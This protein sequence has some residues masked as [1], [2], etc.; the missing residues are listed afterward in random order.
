MDNQDYEIQQEYFAD[1]KSKRQAVSKIQPKGKMGYKKHRLKSNFDFMSAKERKQLNGEV[2]VSN[3]YEDIKNIPTKE[4][5]LSMNFDEAKRV[6]GIAKNLHT[7][8]ALCEQIGTSCGGLYTLYSKFQIPV[9]KRG[10]VKGRTRKPRE[11]KVE[12]KVDNV[13]RVT[14]IKDTPNDETMNKIATLEDS[15]A[16][17]STTIAILQEQL[18]KR[19]QETNSNGFS[20][21]IKGDYDKEHLE[22]KLLN[23]TSILSEGTRYAVNL[24][25]IELDNV[26][27]NND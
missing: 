14:I 20:I 3:K 11:P 21:K 1:L 9:E 17:M 6:L 13:E 26:G 4:Q 23:I 18:N 5:F 22:T 27:E 10:N 7:Q 19:E 2:K 12:A 24:K 16:L 15:V 25:L 8:K